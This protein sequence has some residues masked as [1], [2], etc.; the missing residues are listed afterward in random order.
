MLSGLGCAS[1]GARSSAG[2]AD[3]AAAVSAEE[4]AR[5]FDRVDRLVQRRYYARDLHG[6]NWTAVRERYRP[7]AVAAAD[8]ASWYRA[9]NA[10]LGELRDAHTRATPPR[11]E[12]DGAARSVRAHA[13]GKSNSRQEE[14]P[15]VRELGGGVVHLTFARFDAATVRWLTEQVRLH[16]EARGLIIDLRDNGGGLISAAQR[17]VGLFFPERVAM[18]TVVTRS[19]RRYTEWSRPGRVEAPDVPLVVLVGR[20]SHSSA[21]VFAYVIQHHGRGVL[22]GGR[23]AG[24][25]LGARPHRLPDGGRLYVSETDFHRLE[26]GRLEG[27]GV[28]PD[29]RPYLGSAPWRT[30]ARGDLALHAAVEALRGDHPVLAAM[31]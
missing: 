7:Q 30:E 4:R 6:L 14:A 21:E 5:R 1:A 11:P 28:V 16:R 31:R 27:V 10:M 2:H 17:A 18:G 29:I 25:V 12:P 20:G 13:S 26:G 15:Q 24:E 23:T 22:I 3:P 8:D 9:V 19:G